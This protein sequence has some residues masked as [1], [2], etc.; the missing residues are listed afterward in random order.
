MSRTGASTPETTN[1]AAAASSKVCSLRR[2]SVRRSALLD[3]FCAELGRDPA[4]I[5]RSIILPVSYDE[6]GSTRDTIAEAIDAGFLHIVLSL[7]SPYPEYVAHWV[8]SE[9]ISALGLG[10]VA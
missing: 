10:A 4:S 3:R 9:L 2:A 8:T 5:T 6:P 7:Q 1:T